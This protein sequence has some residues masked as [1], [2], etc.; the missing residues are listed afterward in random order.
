[1]AVFGSEL[2]M[3]RGF[4]KFLLSVGQ[5]EC[6]MFSQEGH[7]LCITCGS[8]LKLRAIDYK[9]PG[10]MELYFECEVCRDSRHIHLGQRGCVDH[11]EQSAA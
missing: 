7:V 10:E 11:Q 1:M 3:K 6:A 2:F 9:T 5:Q 4:V 8:S